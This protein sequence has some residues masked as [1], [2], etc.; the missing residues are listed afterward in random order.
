MFGHKCASLVST[1]L[2]TNTRTEKPQCT[3]ASKARIHQHKGVCAVCA[4][5]VQKTARIECSARS[6]SSYG[7]IDN[8]HLQWTSFVFSQ[9]RMKWVGAMVLLSFIIVKFETQHWSDFIEAEL[10]LQSRTNTCGMWVNGREKERTTIG[11]SFPQQKI[12]KMAL[13][14][15]TRNML[16]NSISYRLRQHL[17]HL[18]T[19]NFLVDWKFMADNWKSYIS[20]KHFLLR[21]ID[22]FAF[23]VSK[24]WKI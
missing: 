16:S 9:L 3:I 18:I 12:L 4:V 21:N 24:S 7:K 22:Y 11:T 5:R 14:V 23:H 6:L 2:N 8:E 10:I 13:K 19:L 20:R 1:M 17:F 15:C